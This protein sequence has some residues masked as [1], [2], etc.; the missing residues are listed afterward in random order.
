MAPQGTKKPS[1]HRSPRRPATRK[2]AERQGLSGPPSLTMAHAKGFLAGALAGGLLGAG[3]IT[4][5]STEGNG[6]SPLALPEAVNS[7]GLNPTHHF[8]FYELLPN[9][10]LDFS[11]DLEPAELEARRANDDLYV[12][13]AGSFRTLADADRRRGE[14]A[15]VGLAATIEQ[16]TSVK[17]T[18]HR[19]YVGPFDSRSAM[20]AARAMTEQQ[21]IDTLLLKRPR[22]AP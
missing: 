14:L 6:G 1:T 9:Q 10:E 4:Y 16:T 11:S 7:S 18:W 5:L 15:L 17:G 13:Q 12:L 3:G 21:S 20:A 19:V 2:G 22:T 8:D